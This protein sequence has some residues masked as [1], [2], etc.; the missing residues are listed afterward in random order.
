[1]IG[2]YKGKGSVMKFDKTDGGFDFEASL[3]EESTIKSVSTNRDNGDL[4]LCG[5]WSYVVEIEG[6]DDGDS[7]T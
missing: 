3:T 4:Y 6:Q 7:T 2:S 5:Q 1:M